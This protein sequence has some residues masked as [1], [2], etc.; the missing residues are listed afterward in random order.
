MKTHQI[1]NGKLLSKYT[2][3]YRELKNDSHHISVYSG[4]KCWLCN[5]RDV[6]FSSAVLWFCLKNQ[7][8]N[9]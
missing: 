6:L 1:K 7:I 8:P 5:K 9:F 4:E 3:L 2:L